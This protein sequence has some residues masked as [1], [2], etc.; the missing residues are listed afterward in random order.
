M[1]VGRCV[2]IPSGA[3]RLSVE[4]FAVKIACSVQ[5]EDERVTLLRQ[6]NRNESL[7][8]LSLISGWSLN[9]T[10]DP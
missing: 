4:P 10:F 6:E 2:L 3:G 7:T 9:Q 8:V 1:V 5:G